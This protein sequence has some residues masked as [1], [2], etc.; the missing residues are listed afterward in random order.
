MIQPPFLYSFGG[1]KG[2]KN[3]TTT[4]DL[5]QNDIKMLVESF[6]KRFLLN[7]KYFCLQIIILNLSHLNCRKLSYIQKF[8][9]LAQFS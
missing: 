1:H 3:N 6:Q 2:Y 4:K 9:F 8:G 5:F 7:N